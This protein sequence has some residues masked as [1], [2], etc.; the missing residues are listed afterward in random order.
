MRIPPARLR[1]RAVAAAAAVATVALLASGCG[2]G[3][4]H[5]S[6]GDGPAGLTAQKMDS[7]A[8]C[9]R[10]HGVLN[11]YPSP[12]GSNPSPASTGIVLSIVGYQVTGVNPQTAQ[13]QSAMKAC[14]H[15]LGLHPP[16]QGIEHKQ[17]L[18]AL[19]QAACMRTH[20]YPSWQD[21][22]EGPNGQGLMVP[23]PP[24]GVDT[25]SPQFLKAAKTCGVG[26]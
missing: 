23:G 7:F 13:F 10:S 17:F 22:A 15:I 12:R 25:S 9:M 20:G 6:P 4:G 26:V 1:A 14:K 2:G 24:P 5:A 3:S 11:F 19:K 8:A 21:P 18:Q 16:S